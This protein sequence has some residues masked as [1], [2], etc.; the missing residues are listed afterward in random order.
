MK[1]TLS[2]SAATT[3]VLILGS[4]ATIVASLMLFQ[5]TDNVISAKVVRDGKQAEY[6]LMACAEVAA[7]EARDTALYLGHETITVVGSITCTIGNRV[8]SGTDFEFPL[9]ATVGDSTKHASIRMATV[10]PPSITI[11]YWQEN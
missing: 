10:G 9:S 3:T 11:N 4:V 1:T 5:S 2:A 8:L 6:A 7:Q